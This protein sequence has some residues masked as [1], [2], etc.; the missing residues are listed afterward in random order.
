MIADTVARTSLLVRA[1]QAQTEN[2]TLSEK[3]QQILDEIA[4]LKTDRARLSAERD[5]V[6]GRCRGLRA[7]LEAM[8]AAQQKAT[9]VR[10]ILASVTSPR[11]PMRYPCAPSLASRFVVHR[12]Q[13]LNELQKRLADANKLAS[14]RVQ[15]ARDEFKRER[16]ILV[17]SALASMKQL[18]A[19]YAQK[20]APSPHRASLAPDAPHVTAVFPAPI[21][22]TTPAFA[23]CT[24]LPLRC[25]AHTA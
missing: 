24:R 7:S 14:S 9:E 21:P 18:R 5:A 19:Q 16:S 10:Y 3:L 25:C 15:E 1:S 11:P 8:D 13:A 17:H 6:E 2:Q 20:P 12:P 22:T 23:V 4:R